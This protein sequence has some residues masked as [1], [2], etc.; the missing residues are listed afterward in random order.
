VPPSTP[1]ASVRT[2]V[3][4][5]PPSPCTHRGL[6]LLCGGSSADSSTPTSNQSCAA[7][8]ATYTTLCVGKWLCIHRVC[9][10]HRRCSAIRCKL[11]CAAIDFVRAESPLG[12]G[13]RRPI[14]AP[15]MPRPWR[16]RALVPCGHMW[17][18]ACIVAHAKKK[19][20]CPSCEASFKAKDLLR[21][22]DAARVTGE[23]PSYGCIESRV[24]THSAR[25]P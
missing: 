25:Q 24:P 8:F 2:C 18:S 9:G 4:R 3:S 21:D 23:S 10:V 11:L 16:D 17:W 7:A 13:P 19:R 12:E 14:P 20:R 5:F 6:E 1:L 22:E 15:P